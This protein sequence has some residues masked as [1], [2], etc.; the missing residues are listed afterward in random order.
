MSLSRLTGRVAQGV[1]KGRG[2]KMCC[3]SCCLLKKMPVLRL[4]EGCGLFND[5]TPVEAV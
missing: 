1:V 2:G 5:E 3:E 4:A